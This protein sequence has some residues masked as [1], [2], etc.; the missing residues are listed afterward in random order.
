MTSV[1]LEKPGRVII[2]SITSLPAAEEA[3][4]DSGAGTAER[5]EGGSPEQSSVRPCAELGDAKCSRGRCA[6]AICN[7]ACH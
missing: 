3:G 2:S 5:D 6:D 4:I 1:E 7:T